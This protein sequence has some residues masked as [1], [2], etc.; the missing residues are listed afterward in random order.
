MVQGY[1]CQEGKFS[2]KSC[3]GNYV[4]PWT[5]ISYSSFL[6][7]QRKVTGDGFPEDTTGDHRKL[8]VESETV[9]HN[10]SYG[11]DN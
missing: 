11:E 9:N 8:D 2:L 4:L 1:I 5:E 3:G 6:T 7:K 10:I